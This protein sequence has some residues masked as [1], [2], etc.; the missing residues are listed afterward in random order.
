MSVVYVKAGRYTYGAKCI[1]LLPDLVLDVLWNALEIK[2]EARELRAVVLLPLANLIQV[3]IRSTLRPVDSL[4]CR[5]LDLFISSSLQPPS[6]G[7]C[8]SPTPA[9]KSSTARLCIV[10][11][12]HGLLG[13]WLAI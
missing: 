12:D 8:R 1:G 4:R 9:D 3:L 5:F 10:D 2:D 6:K 13:R 11:L 7:G